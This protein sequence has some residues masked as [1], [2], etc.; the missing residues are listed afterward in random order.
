MNKKIKY[1]FKESIPV[2]Q[3]NKDQGKKPVKLQGN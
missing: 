3:P 1:S 2:Q